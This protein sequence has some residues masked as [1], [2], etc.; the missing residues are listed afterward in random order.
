MTY[1]GN[2]TFF[3]RFLLGTLETEWETLRENLILTPKKRGIKEENAAA[4]HKMTAGCLGSIWKLL[5]KLTRNRDSWGTPGIPRDLQGTAKI[6]WDP[7]GPPG[8]A[9][10][11]SLGIPA[12]P[13]SPLWGPRSGTPLRPSKT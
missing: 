5:T 3:V 7:L 4:A 6:P 11:G 12:Q 8:I 2:F 10:Q 1:T 9:M 13:V